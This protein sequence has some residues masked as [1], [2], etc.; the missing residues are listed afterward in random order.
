[1]GI[2]PIK[3][4]LDARNYKI[5]CGFYIWQADQLTPIAVEWNPHKEDG[6]SVH[7]YRWQYGKRYGDI[8][9]HV[10]TSKRA[11]FADVL[12]ALQ[13]TDVQESD[14][15]SGTIDVQHM[16]QRHMLVYGAPP[17]QTDKLYFYVDPGMLQ[18]IGFSRAEGNKSTITFKGRQRGTIEHYENMSDVDFFRKVL[19]H[20]GFKEFRLGQFRRG[21]V[22]TGGVVQQLL[23]FRP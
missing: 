17:A 6:R 5:E 3:M 21:T 16:Q 2:T 9:D 13:F 22:H 10:P 7:R 8:V 12:K 14:I 15:V 20:L 18:P 23:V 4:A 11:L 19:K 1:M